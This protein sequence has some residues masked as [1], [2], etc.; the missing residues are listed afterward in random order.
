LHSTAW[1]RTSAYS[2]QHT[3]TQSFTTARGSDDGSILSVLINFIRRKKFDSITN[4]KKK[5][6][7]NAYA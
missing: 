6:N 5:K 3:V 2:T 4:N 7:T 1:Q